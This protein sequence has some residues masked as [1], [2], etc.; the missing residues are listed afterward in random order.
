MVLFVAT[1]GNTNHGFGDARE[2]SSELAKVLKELPQKSSLLEEH[3]VKIF[4]FVQNCTFCKRF[5]TQRQLARSMIHEDR[6]NQNFIIDIVS[7]ISF[8]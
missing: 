6:P 5:K 1:N 2:L 4:R 8:S 3:L 7:G